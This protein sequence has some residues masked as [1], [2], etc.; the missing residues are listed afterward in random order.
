MLTFVGHFFDPGKTGKDTKG[1]PESVLQ[2]ETYA[3]QI[4]GG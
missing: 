3:T 4:V 2:S 1:N